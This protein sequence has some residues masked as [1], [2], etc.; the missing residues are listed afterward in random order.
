MK[1]PAGRGGAREIRTAFD[2]NGCSDTTPPL[3]AQVFRPF[4]ILGEVVGSVVDRLVLVDE[5]GE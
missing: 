3:A 4:R 5:V 2:D 1:R